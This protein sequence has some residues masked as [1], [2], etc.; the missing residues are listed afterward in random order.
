MIRPDL[1]SIFWESC[2]IYAAYL[3]IYLSEF[4]TVIYLFFL[5]LLKFQFY[6]NYFKMQLKYNWLK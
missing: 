4:L 3:S 2:V 5:Q 6:L 1:F